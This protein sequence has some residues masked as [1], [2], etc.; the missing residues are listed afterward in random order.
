MAF[1]A[2]THLHFMQM[3]FRSLFVAVAMLCGI[4]AHSQELYVATEPASNMARHSLGL[5]ISG[6]ASL[7]SDVQSR[8][9]AELMFGANKDLMLHGSVYVSDMYQKKQRFEGY[10]AYAKYRFLSHDSIQKHFRGAAFMRFSSIKNPLINDEINLEGDNSGLQGGLIF[11]QLLHKLALSASASY[12]KAFNNGDEWLSSTLQDDETVGYSLSAGYLLF[13]KAY[14]DYMQTNINL[15]AELLGKTNSQS[16]KTMFDLAPAVQ[17]IVNST[18]R[19]D[20]SQRIQVA[21]NMKRT[22]KNM[23]LVRLE[24]NWYNVF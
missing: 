14:T 5:R 24:Y 17:F 2:M 15:Y 8:T 12:T 23:F 10:G 20:L 13:P 6:E 11:T 4:S 1:I 3:I 22:T 21:G 16:G 18:F 19:I 7:K 9:T